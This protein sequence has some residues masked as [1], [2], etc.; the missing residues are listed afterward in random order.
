MTGLLLSR[1]ATATVERP[2]SAI[3]SQGQHLSEYATAYH[4]GELLL[5][6]D[7]LSC[8]PLLRL[9]IRQSR[10]PIGDR[11]DLNQPWGA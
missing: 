1:V 3:K 8:D 6:R 7:I 10:R 9:A 5:A 4:A 11:G 2:R